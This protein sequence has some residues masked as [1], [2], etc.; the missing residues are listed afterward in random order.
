MGLLH[1]TGFC[2]PLIVTLSVVF[3]WPAVV[4]GESETVA[5]QA[6]NLLS[7]FA[8][9]YADAVQEEQVIDERLYHQQSRQLERVQKLV[10]EL[11]DR[12]G[13]A[14]LERTLDALQ[15]DFTAR[16]NAEQVQ[17]RA[18]T[19][20]DRLAALYQ[21]QRSPIHPLPAAEEGAPL[22]RQHC[23][24]CHGL[25]GGGTEG[26]PALT[27]P[28]RAAQFSLFDFYNL[29]DPSADTL[30][31]SQL[32]ADL[33]S[34]QRWALAVAVAGFPVADQ[35]PPPADL[36]Q[37]YPA[38]VALPGMA[39]TRPGALPEE[40]AAAF[41]WWRGHPDAVRALEHPLVRAGGLLQ[42]AE[43]A[44]RAGDTTGAYY[45]AVLAYRQGYLPLRSQLEKRDPALAAQIQG[46]W[47]EL[48][49]ALSGDSSNAGVLAASQRL[50]ASLAQ[51]R[52]RLEPSTERP[53][54][55]LWAVVLFALAAVTGLLWWRLLRRRQGR[56]SR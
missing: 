14:S 29:L 54:Y 41:L 26:G 16:G 22:Y 25:R 3:T 44:H 46:Q 8:A 7:S 32:G 53:A 48:R 36:A 15:R 43:T 5:A 35:L 47:R 9:D 24:R 12:P 1:K 4:R 2:W 33:N 27:S 56:Q 31:G 38:L 37:R 49:E 19:A 45:K 10:R 51:A 23:A 34:W 21:L 39:V 18:N 50:R 52:N 20:A 11:P 30:H 13:R 17:R 40:A 6:L 28:E 55:V 42:L